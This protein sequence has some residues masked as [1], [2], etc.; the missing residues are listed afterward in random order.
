MPEYLYKIPWKFNDM[1]K[2]WRQI[3]TSNFNMSNKLVS[4][5]RSI[6]KYENIY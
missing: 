2:F 1:V 3:L 4:A 6:F 5:L